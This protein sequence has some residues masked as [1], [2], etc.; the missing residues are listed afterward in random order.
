MP[1]AQ[2]SIIGPSALKRDKV[3]EGYPQQEALWQARRW[4][5]E[6]LSNLGMVILTHEVMQPLPA[7]SWHLGA[8]VMQAIVWVGCERCEPISARLAGR[9]MRG[10]LREEVRPWCRSQ[11]Q[12]LGLAPC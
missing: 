12:P 5:D 6:A 10:P 2:R 9:S 3:E 11:R 7:G 4:G 8:G 1:S